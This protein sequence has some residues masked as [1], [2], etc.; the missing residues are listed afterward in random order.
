M[1]E[2]SKR[3]LLQVELFLT[4]KQLRSARQ[5]ARAAEARAA[6]AEGGMRELERR[7]QKME[8][9]AHREALDNKNAVES[10]R[11]EINR[12]RAALHWKGPMADPETGELITSPQ[13]YADMLSA[14]GLLLLAKDTCDEPHTEH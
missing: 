8:R 10:W 3:S 5:R 2:P 6:A 1:K 11:Y 13:D 9:Q 7:I 14:R 12:S 4:R